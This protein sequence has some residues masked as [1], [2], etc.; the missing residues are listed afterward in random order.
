MTGHSPA[1]QEPSARQPALILGAI[2]VVVGLILLVA[3]VVDIGF[4][5][6]W[7]LWIVGAGGAILLVGL[8]LVPEQPVVVAGSIVTTLGLVLL[9][10]DA[11]GLWQTWAYAW[12]LV[13]PAASGL[14]MLLW[15]LRGGNA[16]AVRAG[17]WGLLGGLALFGLGV[18]FFEGIIGLSGFD[19][20]LPEWTLPAAIIAVGAVVLLRGL[21]QRGEPEGA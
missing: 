13:G 17:F 2:L 8:F 3:Q 18:L 10:Q 1:E 19:L 16:A 21:L 7:P 4:T 12:A 11:T 14:G 20:A 15:G 6:G 9:V 5:L